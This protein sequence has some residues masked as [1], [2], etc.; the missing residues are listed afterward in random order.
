MTNNITEYNEAR[1]ARHGSCLD[2]RIPLG[3]PRAGHVE[4]GQTFQS[5]Y[6]RKHARKDMEGILDCMKSKL[7]RRG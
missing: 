5:Y 2:P 6:R 3:R 1:G 7:T 4:Y